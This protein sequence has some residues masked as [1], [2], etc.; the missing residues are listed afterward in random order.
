MIIVDINGGLGNQMFQYAMA[1]CVSIKNN[2][3][4]KLYINQLINGTYGYEYIKN[5]GG[6]SWYQLD[7]FNIQAHIAHKKDL[8]VLVE[9]N[10]VQIVDRGPCFFVNEVFEHSNSYLFGNWVREDYFADIADVIR[11]D[12]TIRMPLKNNEEKF[13]QLIQSTESVGVH[14]RR[15]PV[16]ANPDCPYNRTVYPLNYYYKA[17][18]IITSKIVNPH[19]FIFSD[20]IKWAQE[21]FKLD[22]PCTFVVTD[23]VA[24]CVRAI[25]SGQQDYKDFWLLKNCKHQIITSST[26]GWWA[27]YLN[28]NK[29]KIIC[30]PKYNNF[31]GNEW[32]V[33][34]LD[35]WIQIDY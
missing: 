33:V 21:N 15:D 9:T 28:E 2:T 19:F 23:S 32:R 5:K 6:M 29:N 4:F 24:N 35:S 8:E 17:I 11:N 31:D 7:A 34:M 12:F 22:V 1:R 30:T 14:L 18:K 10:G 25:D 13:L 26:F 27:A 3:Y 16:A 20:D